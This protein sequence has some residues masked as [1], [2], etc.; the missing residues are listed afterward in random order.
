MH[1]QTG[2]PLIDAGMRQLNQTGYLHNRLR[3]ITASFLVKDLLVDWCWGERY[4]AQQLLDYDLASNNGGWCSGGLGRLRCATVV[5]HFQSGNPIREI[6][7]C[8]HIHSSLLPGIESAAEFDH[9]C[10]LASNATGTGRR[11][12]SARHR[13]PLAH[14][15]PRQPAS[16][17]A[18]PIQERR[19]ASAEALAPRL[20]E[21]QHTQKHRK[22]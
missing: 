16:A 10:A 17:S 6:R 4:F 21:I 11:A 8:R 22:K 13:L 18:S 3:M 2:Y 14:R 19:P 5:P 15:R 12:R 7:I 9:P 20:I 1:G